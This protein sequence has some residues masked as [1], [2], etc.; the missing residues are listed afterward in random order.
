MACGVRVSCVSMAY[1]TEEIRLTRPRVVVDLLRR[2]D[3]RD[4][5][6]LAAVP[7]AL[8]TQDDLDELRALVT[9]PRRTLPVCLLTQPDQTRLGL[10]TAEFLLDAGE[11]AKRT[12]GMVHVATMPTALGFAWTDMVGKPWSAYLGAVRTYRPGLSFEE[13]SPTD[14]PLV[15]AERV[16]AA[17]YEGLFA[18]EAFLE[19]LVERAHRH[20]ATTPVRWG[21]LHF[22]QDAEVRRAELARQN[23]TDDA[24]RMELLADETA[25]LTAK[26]RELEDEC[27]IALSLGAEAERRYARIADENR[28]VSGQLDM[29]RRVFLEKTGESPDALLALPDQLSEIAEWVDDHLAGR[30]VLH[31]RAL[32]GLKDG[33]YSDV[34]LVGRALLLLANEYRDSELGRGE[35]GTLEAF[36][37]GCK[38]LG[39]QHSSSISRT[40]AGE[41][42]ETY[43]V[44][45][46]P[47]SEQSA[48]LEWHLR[49]GKGKDGRRCLA[50]YFF[51][52]RASQQ[53]VVG[54]LPSHL[55]NRMT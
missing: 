8:Q 11:L 46:P 9:D 3:L 47:N 20:V 14:H 44:R 50:I 53:V 5:R 51:W 4:V 40:R 48:F 22:L 24:T 43:F 45:Y 23:A 54:W 28:R 35:R 17:D 21:P 41:Q 32:R 31:P 38:A 16:L 29:L 2:F 10:K 7:W 34:G 33:Q 42:G 49:K 37:D 36:N 19:L 1:D 52:D 39:L 12:M 26:V 6:T 25:A 27:D 13:D 30:L 55:D 15:L 18:E